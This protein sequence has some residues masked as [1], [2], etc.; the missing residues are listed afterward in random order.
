RLTIDLGLQRFLHQTFPDSMRG[1]MVALE[2]RTGHVLAM[3][4]APS[5][6]PNDFVGGISAELWR[7]L[8]ADPAR[9]L[10]PRAIAGRYPPGST[11]KLATAAAALE[12]GQIDP[13]GF[14]P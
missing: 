13:E 14:L 8:N 3:Y 5:Y 7:E 10:L 4:S 9:P 1:A 12:L 6:D 2:P 11:Y